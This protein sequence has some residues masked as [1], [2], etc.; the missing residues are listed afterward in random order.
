MAKTITKTKLFWRGKTIFLPEYLRVLSMEGMRGVRKYLEMLYFTVENERLVEH[1]QKAIV[2]LFVPPIPSRPFSRYLRSYTNSLVLH[3]NDLHLGT[4]LMATT[5]E[6]PYDCWYCSARNTPQGELSTDSIEQ[7]LNVLRSWGT[8]II[9]FTGGEPLLRI[10]TDEI[11]QHFSDDFTFMVFTSGHGLDLNRAKKLKKNGLFFVAISLDD[12]REARHDRA[13][14]RRGAFKTSLGAIKNS[15]TAGLYTI[16][17]S[18]VTSDLLENGRMWNFLEF[19]QQT[20]AD[21]LLLLEPLGTGNLLYNNDN[22][23]LTTQEREKLRWFHEAA[24]SH[25]NLPKI[26]SFADFE[27]KSRFGCGAGIQHAYID[28]H[29]NLWPCNFLPI[30]LGNMISEPEVVRRRLQ[31]YFAHPCNEC[32]LMSKRKQLQKL[33]RQEIPIPFSRVK[34]ILHT[35]LRTSERCGPPAFYA[36][37]ATDNVRENN[38]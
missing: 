35:H 25:T 27:D 5:N 14:G 3:K 26:S 17:Q 12:Y 23:F 6:C 16:I 31:E 28:G 21:E 8:S 19:V 4:V 15:K 9:G 24:L 7:I 29:G 33:A 2:Q 1:T 34:R 20:G 11:I 36:A 38:Q 13:R 30:S 37:M 10:D 32:I 18:V 22:A